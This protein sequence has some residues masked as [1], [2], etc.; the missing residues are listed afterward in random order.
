MT[1]LKNSIERRK[2]SETKNL[3]KL[4]K[5]GHCEKTQKLKKG[6]KQLR[7]LKCDK[8]KLFKKPTM[9]ENLKLKMKQ[10]S[11][12]EKFTKLQYDKTKKKTQYVTKL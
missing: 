6:E 7:N 11:K 10:N 2:K 8:K 12:T 3:K 5:K 9:R 4:F 1:K